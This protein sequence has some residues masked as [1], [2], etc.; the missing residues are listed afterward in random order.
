LDNKFQIEQQ[1]NHK[2]AQ[3]RLEFSHQSPNVVV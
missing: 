2:T 3:E 1:L